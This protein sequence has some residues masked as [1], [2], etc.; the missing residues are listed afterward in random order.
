[1]NTIVTRAGELVVTATGMNTEIGRLAG[2]LRSTDT[3][4]TPLQDHLRVLGQAPRRGGRGHRRCL[5]RPRTA[6]GEPR[7]HAPGLG[8]ARGRRHPRRP[9]RR[10]HRHAGD[11]RGA[12]WPS[13]TPSS[14]AWPRSRR[15][16]APPSSARTR[17]GTLTLNQMT[18]AHGRRGVRHEV[19]RQGTARPATS[20]VQGDDRIDRRCL[21]AIALCNDSRD[22]GDVVG[23]G[24]DRRCAG[25]ARRRRARSMWPTSV[26][27]G[28]GGGG[29]VRLR[30]QVHGDRPRDGHPATGGGA[31]AP[32]TCCSTV[33][34]GHRPRRG[35][36]ARAGRHGSRRRRDDRRRRACGCW[37]S[38]RDRRGGGGG[39]RSATGGPGWHWSKADLAGTRRPRRPAPTRG[40]RRHRDVHRPASP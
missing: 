26:P 40:P 11:R 17:P 20:D 6:R 14:S 38:P 34:D 1:M 29:A 13:A 35:A 8:C 31:R 33:H 12:R 5:L 39:A 10:H 9:A 37:R 22:D 18:A 3:E 32:P 21:E 28:P 16:G 23:R 4:R 27:T 36:A 24:S 2:L 25:G 30:S 15:S 19:S 7:R